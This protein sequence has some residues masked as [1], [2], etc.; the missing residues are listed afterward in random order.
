MRTIIA[1]SILSLGFAADGDFNY[2]EAGADW[3]DACSSGIRQSPID[4]PSSYSALNGK[5]T[6]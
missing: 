2:K 5:E 3:G 6:T 1:S 4:L